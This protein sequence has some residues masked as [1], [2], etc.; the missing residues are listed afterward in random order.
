MSADDFDSNSDRTVFRQPVNHPDRTIIKPTPGGKSRNTGS[1][2][3]QIPAEVISSSERNGLFDIFETHFSPSAGLNPLLIAANTLIE[4]FGEI[5][6]TIGH[7]NINEL[8][9]RL[10]NEVKSFETKSQQASIPGEIVLSSRY[11]LCTILDEAI[12]NTPWGAESNW[13][14]RSLLSVFHNETTGGEKFYLILEK[15]KQTPAV[16]VDILE[17]CYICLS[18]GFE[19]KYR[20]T[21]RGRQNIEILRNELFDIIRTYRGDYERTLSPNWQGLGQVKNTMAHYFPLW[22]VI[23]IASAVVITTY[24]GFRIWVYDSS[25]P[26]VYELEKI[27]QNIDSSELRNISF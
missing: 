23:S 24:I 25:L 8:H 27:S 18:L 12:L 17:L 3:A 19:G 22:A 5:K 16:N 9:Q 14:Q 15:L 13:H 7:S 2:N 11:I 26:V 10:I 6:Q 21:S 1:S 20:L 4:V